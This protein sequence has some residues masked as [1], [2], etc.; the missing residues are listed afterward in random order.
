MP[1]IYDQSVGTFYFRRGSGTGPDPDPKPAARCAADEALWQ[2][3]KQ[4]NT[5]EGYDAYL[6][7]CEAGRFAAFARAAKRK[8]ESAAKVEV[9]PVA[10]EDY[11]PGKAFRDCGDCPEMVGVPGGSFEMGSLS[12]KAGR[13]DDEGPVRMV[14][15][16][17]FG[18]GKTEVTRGQFRRF[19]RVTGRS[20]QGCYVYD[21]KAWKEDAGRS[22]E[23]PGYEQTDEHP[24]VCVSWEDAQAYVSWLSGNTGKDYRLPSESEWEYAARAGTRSVRHWGDGEG[25]ACRY[26]NVADA[27]GKRKYSGWTTFACDDGYAETAPVGSF[28][29][30]GF[31]LK[32]MLGNVNEWTQDCYEAS[33]VGSP[34][35]GSAVTASGCARRAVRG[36]SWYG[37]PALVR[38]AVR[39]RGEPSV[40][41]SGSGFRVARTL[42]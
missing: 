31:G 33:Y 40:R 16:G 3:A 2:E 28:Q 36:G 1:A 18:L 38:S 10:G 9:P 27:A 12:T 39:Y 29:G 21:G 19:V 24:V 5:V 13:D 15:V 41:F 8:L 22:W 25:E 37:E 30:N 17:R 42:P 4:M 7:E 20:V 35:D 32:D 26:A 11:P 23:S 6:S 14:R 34:T